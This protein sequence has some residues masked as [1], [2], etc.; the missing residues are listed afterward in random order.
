[1]RPASTQA[2]SIL[3][4]AL[5]TAALAAPLPP[6]DQGKLT[7]E[8]HE[9]APGQKIPASQVFNSLGCTGQNLSP[10]LSWTHQPTGTQS[11]A[12]VV[13]DPDAPGDGWWHW[14]VHDIP[15][16]VRSLPTGAGDP[17]KTLMPSGAIQ[18]RNDFGT[19]GYGGPC[20]PAGKPHRYFFWLYALKVPKLEVPKDSG[21]ASVVAKIR[22]SA[23]AHAELMGVYER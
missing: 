3:A 18:E 10:T 15:K 12:L 14:I 23:I 13:F 22:A 7:L 16:E 2:G 5:A 6:S 4:A 21:P 20:P 17:S 8:S 1:M 19:R 11:L 9:I